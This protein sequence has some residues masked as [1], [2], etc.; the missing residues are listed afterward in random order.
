MRKNWGMTDPNTIQRL[1]QQ[2]DDSDLTQRAF[3]VQAGVAYSTFTSWLRKFRA[4]DFP[5]PPPAWIEAPP[6]PSGVGGAE[7]GSDI[8]VEWPNGLR[9]HVR[10]GFDSGDVARLMELSAGLCSR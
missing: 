5:D 10:P 7:S 6:A 2:Y 3:A 8:V 9:L 4:D 1:L